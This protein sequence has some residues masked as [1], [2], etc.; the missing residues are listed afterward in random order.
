MPEEIQKADPKARRIAIILV[1]AGVAVGVISVVRFEHTRHRFAAW[2]LSDPDQFMDRARIVLTVIAVPMSLALFALALS[3]WRL[4]ARVIASQ[5]FPPPGL[6]VIRDTRVISGARA[7]RFARVQLGFAALVTLLGILTPFA[8][9]WVF[10]L[11]K[12]VT[13]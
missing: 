6:A 3:S 1:L 8:S 2:L 11:L 5:R 12:T 9:W 7:R 4:A 10:E 13:F